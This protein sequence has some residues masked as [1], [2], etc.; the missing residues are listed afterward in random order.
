VPVKAPQRS[1]TR[2][3]SIGSTSPFGK[4]GHDEQPKSS[5][6]SQPGHPFHSPQRVRLVEVMNRRKRLLSQHR[7]RN[8]AKALREDASHQFL[9][10]TCC[11]ENPREHSTPKLRT[12]VLPTVTSFSEPSVGPQ[13]PATTPNSLTASPALGGDA[14]GAAPPTAANITGPG[15]VAWCPK[16]K[17]TK[18]FSAL[19]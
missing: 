10:P 9:Q 1:E 16:R 13:K 5:F 2:T 8:P 19:G 14:V 11:H 7:P 17:L 4:V 12:L 6:P 15:G 18:A 3:P